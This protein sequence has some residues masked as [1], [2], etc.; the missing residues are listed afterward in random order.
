[1]NM[2]GTEKY[3]RQ[4]KGT[5]QHTASRENENEK[6]HKLGVK[7]IHISPIHFHI[8][9]S[10]VLLMAM[11]KCTVAKFFHKQPFLL[12]DYENCYNYNYLNF[13]SVN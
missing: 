10:V 2:A 6:I 5:T 3:L 9:L 7:D 1:M 12:V 13:R 4:K 8:Y 11:S